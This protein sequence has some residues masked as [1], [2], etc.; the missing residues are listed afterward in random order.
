MISKKATVQTKEIGSNVSISE[1][2]V[3]RKN[4]TIGNGVII[5]PHVTINEGV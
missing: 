5:H 1:Y 3:I 4:V 2:C